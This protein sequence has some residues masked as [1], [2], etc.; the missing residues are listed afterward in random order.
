M[1]G[2]KKTKRAF[3]FIEV[4]VVISIF[5]VIT[6]I[7]F[8]TLIV[9]RRDWQKQEIRVYLSQQLRGAMEFMM[10]DISS[11]SP[12]QVNIPTDGNWHSQLVFHIPQD[13][14][15]DG[16]VLDSNNEVEWSSDITYLLSGDKILRTY[17]ADTR[18]I[19]SFISSLR[20]R[21]TAS[22]PRKLEVDIEA[23]RNTSYQ[24]LIV[25]NLTFAITL[26]N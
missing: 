26:K 5:L 8:Y 21:R 6:G 12:S 1:E 15:G 14:D 10:E 2:N 25:Q 17:Q 16:T 19:A 18:T 7:F 9:L 23:S 22:N 4:M 24:D 11:S 13:I 20:F 3:T